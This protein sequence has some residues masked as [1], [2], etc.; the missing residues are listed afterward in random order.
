MLSNAKPIAA[1]KIAVLNELE[2]KLPDMAKILIIVFSFSK[3]SVIPDNLIQS[4]DDEECNSYDAGHKSNS[5]SILYLTAKK[6]YTR[7]NTNK[8]NPDKDYDNLLALPIYQRVFCGCNQFYE[9]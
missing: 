7:G 5:Q 8:K 2:R 9:L 4:R 1:R 6:S 3:R